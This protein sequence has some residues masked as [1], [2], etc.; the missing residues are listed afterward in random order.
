MCKVRQGGRQ[1]QARCLLKQ[2]ITNSFPI[3]APSLLLVVHSTCI[4]YTVSRYIDVGEVGRGYNV[5]SSYSMS[6]YRAYI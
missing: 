5:P 6:Y 4:G 1:N 3:V 2:K